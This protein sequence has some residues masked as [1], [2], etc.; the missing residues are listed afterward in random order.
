MGKLSLDLLFIKKFQKAPYKSEGL[1]NA[2][3]GKS[4]NGYMEEV[5]F[6]TWF[7]DHFIK[8]SNQSVI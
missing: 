2:L 7:V 3:Y 8:L 1:V 5:L 6:R 4:E